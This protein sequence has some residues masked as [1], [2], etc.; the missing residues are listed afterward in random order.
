LSH[1]QDKGRDKVFALTGFCLTGY[2]ESYC[3]ALKTSRKNSPIDEKIIQLI[4]E[5]SDKEHILLGNL[6]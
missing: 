4:P 1:N 5:N 6:L 2:A 3:F